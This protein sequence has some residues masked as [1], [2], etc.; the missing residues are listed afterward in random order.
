MPLALDYLRRIFAMD[1]ERHFKWIPKQKWI[2]IALGHDPGYLHFAHALEIFGIAPPHSEAIRIGIYIFKYII[3]ISI[4]RDKLIVKAILEDFA[5]IAEVINLDFEACD[6]A[7]EMIIKSLPDIEQEMHMIRHDDI[8]F[9]FEGR[10]QILNIIYGIGYFMANQ[11]PVG[12][13]FA[14]AEPLGDDVIDIESGKWRAVRGFGESYH[15]AI[16]S[17][18]IMP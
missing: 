15:I 5:A 17:A 12:E 18:V 1:H 6:I 8:V 2:A 3:Q 10:M 13:A 7:T 16:R 14:V 4:W 11:R 9:C